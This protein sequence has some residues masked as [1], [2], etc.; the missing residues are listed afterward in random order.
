[1]NRMLW[2]KDMWDYGIIM[3]RLLFTINLRLDGSGLCVRIKGSSV[4]HGSIEFI[5]TA[6]AM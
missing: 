6:D 5:N 1:M 3:L 4:L 2:V